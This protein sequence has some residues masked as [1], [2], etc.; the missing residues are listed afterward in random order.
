MGDLIGF[1]G[2]DNTSAPFSPTEYQVKLRS[3]RHYLDFDFGNT[4]NTTCHYPRFWDETGFPV[5]AN[6]DPEFGQL[7]GCYD[8]EFGQVG[9]L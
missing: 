7:K 8:S 6:S 9:L 4:Y 1:K 3:D 5:T 2:F